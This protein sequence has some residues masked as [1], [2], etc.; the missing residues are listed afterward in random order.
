[1]NIIEVPSP[2]HSSG[3]KK[4]RP[5]AIVIHIMEGSLAGTDS[6]FRDPRS[7][8]SAHYGVGKNGEVHRYVAETN[9]AWHAGR[10]NAPSWPLIRKAANGLFVNPNLYTIGIEHEGREDTDWSEAMYQTSAALIRDICT[11]WNIPIDREHII[12]HHEIYALKTCPGKKVNLAK[13]I[14]LAGGTPAA[15]PTGS[16]QVH[17]VR[18]PEEGTVKTKSRMRI[19]PM[20]STELPELYMVE[21]NARLSFSGYTTNGEVINGNGKWYYT[22]EETWFWSGTVTPISAGDQ[23]NLGAPPDANTL[24]VEQIRAATGA[25]MVHA[26]KFAPYIIEACNRYN[27][28]TPA[29]QL[30]F[31]AQVG[32]ESGGLFFTEEIA[33]GRA[34][35]HRKD[36]GNTEPGD[37]VR[38]KG[39]GL[40]QITGRFNYQALSEA[41]GVDLIENPAQLGGKNVN[42]CTAEQLRNAALSAGWFWNRT[43]LNTIADRINIMEPVES[44]DNFKRFVQMTRKINGG[45]NGLKDRIHKY[46]SGVPSFLPRE[47]PTAGGVQ[48]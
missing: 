15:A 29:R 33:S 40:I 16:T 31:L 24:S 42:V 9:T 45:T 3:R 47:Q 46:L 25:S 28:D 17:F 32:H 30:C 43:K 11:R 39:R 35:E 36:L 37:G 26:A 13:L 6:W 18:V 5:E 1:M 20:P 27:I 19:R 22:A 44:G 38:F 14:M 41:F 34:Y 7:K 8:V 23:V 48:A 12:G 2:H 4:Y 10:V 21:P